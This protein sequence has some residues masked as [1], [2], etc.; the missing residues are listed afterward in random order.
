MPIAYH[1]RASSIFVSGAN[2]KRLK[3]QI[4]KKGQ[5]VLTFSSTKRLDFKLETG[6]IIGGNSE[7]QLPIN[8]NEASDYIFGFVLFNDWSAR[9]IQ[10]WKYVPLGPF[11]GK[12]FFSSISPWVVTSE[13]LELFK[14]PAKIQ[15]PE[16]LEYLQGMTRAQLDVSLEVYLETKEGQKKLISRSSYK[17]L[18]WTLA[19]QIAHH[20]VNG[21]N[22]K[23]RDILA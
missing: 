6:A 16:P 21:C 9:D 11:L 5:E 19:Q 12:N 17:N 23:I 8:V 1:G 14:V 4:K 18:Y 10:Q 2:F 22:L 15:N 7:W 13:A 20:T 3:G